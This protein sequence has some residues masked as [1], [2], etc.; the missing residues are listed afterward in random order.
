[1]CGVCGTL[2]GE[3]HWT[4]G[5]GRI[6][7]GERLTRRAERAE[8]IR[9]LNQ[10]L[11]SLN[12]RISDWQGRSFVVA[13]STGKQQ[14]VDSVSHIWSAV[15]SMTGRCIDPLSEFSGNARSPDQL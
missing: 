13:G 14:V 11:R 7:G 5:A 2:G 6:Q 9:V 1:M 10:V 8:R 3:D 15:Q 12:V 4:S